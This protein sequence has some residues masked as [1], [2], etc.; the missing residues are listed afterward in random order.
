LPRVSCRA[1][2]I[3]AP[4]EFRPVHR[5][6]MIS[7]GLPKPAIPSGV[8]VIVLALPPC[9]S[10]SGHTVDKERHAV[11]GR[12]HTL[13]ALSPTETKPRGLAA[14]RA[15][16]VPRSHLWALES[17]VDEAANLEDHLSAILAVIVRGPTNYGPSAHTRGLRSG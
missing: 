9:V 10:G 6:A 13:A 4:G 8:A 3:D 2:S 1:I 12:D 17:G 15:A 11:T 14:P 7:E 5:M 16:T